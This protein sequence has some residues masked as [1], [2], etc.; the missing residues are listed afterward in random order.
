M[1]LT[2]DDSNSLGIG[3]SSITITGD[4]YIVEE[5]TPDEPVNV[6]ATQDQDGN[7]A[8]SFGMT[9][10]KT[11]TAVLQKPASETTAL[12]VGA[13]TG[14]YEGETW[15]V[16]AVNVAK[17]IGEQHKYNISLVKKYN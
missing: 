5:F 4:S 7:A 11:A 2:H 9:G 12:A 14:S 13:E 10:L 15:I 16:T 1:A 3:L 6:V 8:G 17:K